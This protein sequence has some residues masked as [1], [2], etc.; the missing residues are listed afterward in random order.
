MSRDGHIAL[1]GFIGCYNIVGQVSVGKLGWVII[2]SFVLLNGLNSPQG[3]SYIH[4]TF[5]SFPAKDPSH[6]YIS[7]GCAPYLL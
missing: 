6:I 2:H 1:N 4:L 5:T 3:L 7:H